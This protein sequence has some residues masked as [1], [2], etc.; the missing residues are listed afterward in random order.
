MYL[1]P[2]ASRGTDKNKK[3]DV[4]NFFGY[5]ERDKIDERQMS[6]MKNMS[7]DSIPAM[8]PRQPRQLVCR[9]SGITAMCSPEYTPFELTEFTGVAGGYFYYNGEKIGN[10]KLSD[11]EKSIADFGGNI[12]IFPDKV[13]YRYLPDPDSGEIKHELYDMAKSV[14]VSGALFYSSYN[15]ITGV[16]SAYIQKSGAGFND[17]FSVGDSVVISGCSNAQNNTV[18]TESRKSYAAADSIVSAVVNEATASKLSLLMYT[19]S[20]KYALFK[21][22]T[23]SANVKIEVSIPDM[24]YVCVHNNRLWGTSESGE[25]VY[26][27]KL[28]DCFNFNSFQGLQDDSWF[29]EIGTDG[30]FTGITSYR[31]AVVAF[32][33]NYIH[34]IYGDSPLNFSIPKQTFGGAADGRSIAEVGGVLYY[35]ADDGFYEYTGGEPEK[36]SGCIKTVYKKCCSGTDGRRYYA[37]TERPGGETDVLVYDPSCSVWH[38]EDNTKF[39]SFLK[40]NEYLYGATNSEMY[41]FGGGDEDVD[42]C[43]VSKKF[44]LDDIDFKGVNSVYIRM[45]APV[46]T[47]VNVYTSVDEDE[48]SPAGQICG[49]GFIVYRIPVRFKK[50]DSF[51][52]MLE[53]SGYAVVHDIE[54][55]TYKGGRTNVKNIR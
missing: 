6:E 54:I 9:R 25:Y 34:H 33:R 5:D 53:G 39:V 55:V 37:C 43:V 28:G 16:Y 12:C 10:K 26:A 14:T 45:D 51:R 21:N 20:G 30:S 36:I 49:S 31:T 32:K 15:S 47:N 46:N 1:P 42:W 4:L 44:T 35:M 3:V 50:C 7:S 38:K 40:H 22:M 17:V 19:K 52:I 8:S 13:Y 11:T 2:A 27:S 48:F 23:D 29:S 18:V 24:N 41:K